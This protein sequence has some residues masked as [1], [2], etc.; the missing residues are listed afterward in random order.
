MGWDFPKG[1]S[2]NSLIGGGRAGMWTLYN[3]G[4][5]LHNTQLDSVWIISISPLIYSILGLLLLQRSAYTMPSTN[6]I[7]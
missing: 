7:I 5:S 6:D 1:D 3:L 4:L 2:E